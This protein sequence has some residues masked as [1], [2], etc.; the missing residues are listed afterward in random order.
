[1]EALAERDIRP[2]DGGFESCIAAKDAERVGAVWGIGT[3]VN[4]DGSLVSFIFSGERD[5]ISIPAMIGWRRSKQ[6][7]LGLR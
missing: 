2:E 3:G 6:P 7:A 4:S 5:A 1:L